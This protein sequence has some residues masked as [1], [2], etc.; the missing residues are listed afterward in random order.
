M[1]Q[2]IT[3]KSLWGVQGSDFEGEVAELPG[4]HCCGLQALALVSAKCAW[5][6]GLGF[7]LVE[8]W[9]TVADVKIPHDSGRGQGCDLSLKVLGVLVASNDVA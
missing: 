5:F 2:K 1:R 7:L 4:L 9:W 6:G 3:Q 8:T